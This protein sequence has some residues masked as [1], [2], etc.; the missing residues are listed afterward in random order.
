M[1]N[2]VGFFTIC[3]Q[4]EGKDVTSVEVEE[5]SLGSQQAQNQI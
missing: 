5:Q 4:T 1:V 3:E 2:G